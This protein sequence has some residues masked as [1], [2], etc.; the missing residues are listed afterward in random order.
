M[1]VF[2]MKLPEGKSRLDMVKAGLSGGLT[3]R[4]RLVVSLDRLLEDPTVKNR[5]ALVRMIGKPDEWVSGMLRALSLPVA[6]QAKVGTSQHSM[7]YDAMIR[8]A[9][10]KDPGEQADWLEAALKGSS[11]HEI[12][13]RIN[14]KTE[15][16]RATE[17][18]TERV[19]DFNVTVQGP[20]GR[21]ANNKMRTAVEGLLRKLRLNNS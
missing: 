7:W 13:R 12:R 19:G 18:I 8:I 16:G 2:P 15:P 3:K 14:E 6:L 21:G 20:A 9:R 11:V 17:W 10:V 1:P 5:A 4:G